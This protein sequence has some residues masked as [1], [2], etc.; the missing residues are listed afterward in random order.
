M[1]VTVNLFPQACVK[2][3]IDVHRAVCARLKPT[4]AHAQYVFSLHDIVHVIEGMLL[5]S[6]RTK[7]KQ[8]VKVK[9]QEL[10]DNEMQTAIRQSEYTLSSLSHVH[11]GSEHYHLAYHS[12]GWGDSSVG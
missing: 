10:R 7:I 11:S 3:I 2:S 4:P 6:P 5:L 9:A 1:R 12:K 8:P